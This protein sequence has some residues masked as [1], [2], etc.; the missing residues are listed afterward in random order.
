MPTRTDNELRNLL[1]DQVNDRTL[2]QKAR[3]V[4]AVLRQSHGIVGAPDEEAVYQDICLALRAL[5][6]HPECETTHGR[7]CVRRNPHDPNDFT[8]LLNLGSFMVFETKEP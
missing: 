1:R 5:A 7:V 4:S 6:T 2:R 3:E 8:V